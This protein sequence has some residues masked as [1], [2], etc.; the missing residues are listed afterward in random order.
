MIRTVRSFPKRSFGNRSLGLTLLFLLTFISSA[1][2]WADEIFSQK[3]RSVSLGMT[4]ENVLS[5]LG[6]PEAVVEKSID[7]YGRS[8]E[9]WRYFPGL[10]IPAQ[11]TIASPT[12]GPVAAAVSVPTVSARS[13][14]TRARMEQASW[15]GVQMAG[16]SN[17]ASA[18][19]KPVL[20]KLTPATP[21]TP[22]VRQEA[23]LLIF[24][25][26]VVQSV[27]LS[28]QGGFV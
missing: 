15:R 14:V 26:G 18:N 19:Y 22:S 6:E 9:V 5:I 7:A 3:L 21:T 2:V 1:P 23:Y 4:R 13:G 10:N 27:Q 11:A 12:G 24:V 20:R 16:R 17:P 28:N 8:V 25:N